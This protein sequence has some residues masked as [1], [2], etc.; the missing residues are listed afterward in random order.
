MDSFTSRIRFGISECPSPVLMM[1]WSYL[2]PIRKSFLLSP[3]YS[4]D[5]PWTSAVQGQ[6]KNWFRYV[7]IAKSF[8]FLFSLNLNKLYLN[9][10]TN[11]GDTSSYSPHTWD[12]WQS[13]KV[14]ANFIFLLIP[15]SCLCSIAL[16][17]LQVHICKFP[18]LV[19]RHKSS[20]VE[21]V[22]IGLYNTHAHTGTHI[23]IPD[24]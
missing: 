4:F 18:I 9:W 6:C 24:C 1:N 2:G 10:Q 20:P 12:C 8:W 22:V 23:Y 19:L 7:V 3:V 14:S 17:Q 13:S 15:L 11:R 5:N 16:P 21:S